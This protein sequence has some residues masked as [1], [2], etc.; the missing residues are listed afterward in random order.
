[1]KAKELRQKTKPELDKI[2]QELRKNLR[3]L[4]FKLA[5]NKVKNIKE[6]YQAKKDIARIKT[7]AR[8]DELKAKSKRK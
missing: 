7:L 4:R 8:E 3:Q 1:M 5:S 6:I 2:L